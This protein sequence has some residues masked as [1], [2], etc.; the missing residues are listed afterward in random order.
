MARTGTLADEALIA[1]DSIGE[2]TLRLFSPGLRLGVT[3]LSRSGKTVFI[4]ALVHNLLHGGRL[5]MFEPAAS[6]RL[7]RAN[8]APQPSMD[9]PR[10]AY[11]D[12]VRAL[13]EERVWPQSTRAIA[14]LRIA[15]EYE[16]ASAWNRTFGAGRLNIDI[17][18]YPGE[19]LGDLPL[20]GLDYDA[21]SGRALEQAAGGARLA[22]ARRF[23]A[24]AQGGKGA[25]EPGG[26]EDAARA[27]ADAFTRYLRDCRSEDVALSSLSPGRFLMPG[28]LEGSPALTF[29]PMA[30][31]DGREGLRALMAAR[32]E[33]YKAIVVKPFFRQHFARL[34]R[35]IVLVDLFAA[36]NA[37]PA[38]LA[39]LQRALD[40][41]LD[42]FRAGRAGVFA[43]LF[44]PRIDRILFAAAKA[45]HL[46]HENHDR[47]EAL[48]ARLVANAR[49]KAELA[50]AEIRTVALASVRAT[51]E[52]TLR[53]RGDALP[54]IVGTPIDGETIDGDTFDG[55][56]E[57]AVFPGDLPA[58]PGN[59][60]GQGRHSAPPLRFVRF[61]PPR[62]E[63]D[64]DGLRLT[65]PH[66]RLDR[67]M[68][69]L[70]G[71]R[72]A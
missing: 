15:V 66:I 70:L 34:D 48:L 54:A 17:V 57:T 53:D 43:S 59:L 7:A 47:L 31:E 62:L 4:T 33:A 64:G 35:Q 13:V 50:G 42:C 6:G 14:E 28:D 9:V 51:R 39:D 27:M 41:I 44:R 8:L 23:L 56:T 3:G 37:G 30:R 69:F 16:S 46:H 45:D 63:A 40:D 10:F 72:L 38:A 2:A 71:D 26:E 49:R 21:W 1:L 61:R 11:E 60:L 68:Q 65:L 20:L 67:T 5:P 12:H 55:E 24:L 58:D 18:D 29:A 36:I 19:W 22:P 25:I 52:A 32:Y